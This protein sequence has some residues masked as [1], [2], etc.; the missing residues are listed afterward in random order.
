MSINGK[1][2]TAVN[3]LLTS[4]TT[5]QANFQTGLNDIA[6][7]VN[8]NEVQLQNFP[9]FQEVHLFGSNGTL[10]MPS[11]HTRALVFLSGG[12]GGGARGGAEDLPRGGAAGKG[13]GLITGVTPGSSNS[14]T[15]G[16]GGSAGTGDSNGGT[17]GTS[18]AFGFNASGGGGAT[19]NQSNTGSSGS[20]TS[21]G[22]ATRAVLATGTANSNSGSS[23]GNTPSGEMSIILRLMIPSLP[24]FIFSLV[25]QNVTFNTLYNSMHNAGTGY[26]D[27]RTSHVDAGAGRS[28]YCA[29]WTAP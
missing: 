19:W 9:L 14:I 5:T 1:T 3:D 17:G 20:F 26:A 8:A 23:S 11:G 2:L 27:R 29:I 25:E 22:G 12:G 28:G 15:I 4:T 24:G 16:N 13:F 21:S 18:S 7:Q 6:F 10:T